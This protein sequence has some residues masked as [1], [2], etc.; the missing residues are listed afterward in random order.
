M[1]MCMMVVSSLMMHQNF[2]HFYATLQTNIV[3][4]DSLHYEIKIECVQYF[5]NLSDPE[6]RIKTVF[7]S[8]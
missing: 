4:P 7:V 1:A 3:W 6:Y 8:K 2:H 5:F